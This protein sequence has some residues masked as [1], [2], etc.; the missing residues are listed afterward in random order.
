MS[1]KT[2][3][4]KL[5][6]TI[7]AIAAL[8]AFG[9]WKADADQNQVGK[10]GPAAHAQRK[11]TANITS[12]AAL[13]PEFCKRYPALDDYALSRGL[14]TILVRAVAIT[15]SGLDPC[16]VSRVVK[17]PGQG[18]YKMG[19]DF[20]PDPESVCNNAFESPAQPDGAPMW[21]Y[22]GLGLMGTTEPP[23]TF[24]PADPAPDGKTG[25]YNYGASKRQQLFLEA[26]LSGRLSFLLDARACSAQFNPFNPNHS[27]CLGTDKLAKAMDEARRLVDGGMAALD[28]PD[29]GTTGTI[30][31]YLALH[32]YHG[33]GAGAQAWITGFG[34]QRRQTQGFCDRKTG[35]KDP[36][37]AERGRDPSCYGADDFVS[38][39]RGCVFRKGQPATALQGDAG[40]L[41]GDYGSKVLSL[42]K[43]L[44]KT[45]K[46]K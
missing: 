24:W 20:V 42:Y 22:C 30:T 28:Y 32:G 2:R 8:T 5:K 11:T 1:R 31:A 12:A 41:Y 46:G 25:A 35:K 19:Y 10:R 36:V 14:D 16:A 17:A 21:R 38:F 40:A 4:T 27:A 45:C 9:S 39:V 3:D 23:Y 7:I 6:T 37:C 13:S 26:Q 29:M 18:C 44:E 43:G 33:D 34:R 15:E